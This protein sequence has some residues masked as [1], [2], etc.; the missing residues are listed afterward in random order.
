MKSNNFSDVKAFRMALYSLLFL[1]MVF[2]FLPFILFGKNSIITIH[3]NLD[4]LP[5]WL[6]MFHDNDLL[7]KFDA[8]TKGFSEMSTLYYGHINFSFQSLLFYFFDDFIAYIICYYCSVIFGFFSMF[9]FLRR[10]YSIPSP[11]IFLVPVCY[12]VL[13]V[14]PVISIGVSTLPFIVF[15]F[16]V[17]LKRNTFSWKA[18]LLFFFP[19]FSSFTMVGIFILG[20]WFVGFFVASV[21]NK[22][23]NINLLVGFVFLCIGYIT[24]DLK[25][26]YAMFIAKEPLNRV[27]FNLHPSSFVSMLKTFLV[28]LK[29][30]SIN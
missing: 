26:F 16:F 30:Y 10:C 13:P 12:A 7:F 6:K 17:F 8:P 24:V 29:N 25:L 19:F 28:S 22:R 2:C 18:L 1:T 20:F 15:I 9:F 27:A 23:L 3:D 21:K 5:A 4:M 11:L 14:V